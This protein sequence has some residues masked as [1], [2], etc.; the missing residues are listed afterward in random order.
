MPDIHYTDA[1]ISVLVGG[2]FGFVI[3]CNFQMRRI[4]RKMMKLE[5]RLTKKIAKANATGALMVQKYFD[6]LTTQQG[7]AAAS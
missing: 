4:D 1:M 5:K 3:W 7:K 2:G 6:K